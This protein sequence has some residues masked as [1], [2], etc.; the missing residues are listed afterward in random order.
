MRSEKNKTISI[1][2]DLND[3]SLEIKPKIE[4]PDIVNF[5][6]WKYKGGD[7]VTSTENSFKRAQ[8]G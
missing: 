6:T 1:S 8:I 4:R 5:Y 3:I 2:T 7:S